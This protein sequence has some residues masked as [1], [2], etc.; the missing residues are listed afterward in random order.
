MSKRPSRRSKPAPPD[1]V[2]QLRAAIARA[3]AGGMTR[4]A[5]AKA[6]GVDHSQIRR[7]AEGLTVPRLDTAE[8]IAAA[9]GCRVSIEP[10]G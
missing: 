8:R 10:A 2:A 5:I 6:V 7:V 3:E 1:A 9:I 4:Y